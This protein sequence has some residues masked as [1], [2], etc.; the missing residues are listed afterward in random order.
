MIEKVAEWI[1]KDE[2]I[3]PGDCV[4][5]GVSG[6]ADSVCLLLL[7]LKLRQRLRFTVCAVHVEHGIR[8]ADSG[9]DAAF[10]EELCRQRQIPCHTCAVDVPAYAAR[11][12]LGTEEAARALRYECYLK[13][14]EKLGYERVRVAL[15]HHADDNAETMLFSL[16]RGSGIAGLGGI[17]A[18]RRLSERVTIIRPLL[19]ATRTQIEAWLSAQGQ[20]YC[21]DAT[22]EDT[23]YSRNKIRHEVMPRLAEVNRKAVF[24]MAQSARLLQETADY[25][26]REAARAAEQTC[27]FGRGSCRIAGEVFDE[28]PH[29]IRSEAV[30]RVLA[31]TA[32]SGKDIGSVHVEAVL[33]LAGMQVGRGVDLPYGLRAARVYGGIFIGRAGEEM[34]QSGGNAPARV[35]EIPREELMR[36]E[37]GEEL[38]VALDGGEMRL[39]ILDFSGR[40]EEIPKKKYTKWLNYDKIKNSLQIR[41]R[42]AGDYLTIDGQG[43]HKKLKAYF[44]DEKIPAEKRDDIWLLAEDAKIL[45]VVGGRI[46]ADSR[47]DGHTK[48]ILEVRTIGGSYCED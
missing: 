8:G 27:V 9:R 38:S 1:E 43:H 29:I 25:I 16:A 6:G 35:R 4:L 32:G 33:A 18:V 22:N 42:M 36:L 31:E 45:W 12:G 15:A 21:I 34:R 20:P 23:D 47:A 17:R 7:L 13:V 46:G 28:Y 40:T 48:K 24:H 19:A 11:E 14:A 41:K 3:A 2:L 30:R 39:R 26:G 5:A 10:V 44:T 37:A